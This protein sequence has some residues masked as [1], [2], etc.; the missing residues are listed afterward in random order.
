M[1]TTQTLP[2]MGYLHADSTT[3][4]TLRFEILTKLIGIV[5]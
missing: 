1:F 5:P 4:K 3:G 2:L